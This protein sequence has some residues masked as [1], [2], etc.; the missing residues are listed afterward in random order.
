MGPRTQTCLIEC[1]NY[2]LN[3][4]CEDYE[5]VQPSGIW[6]I[7]EICDP[8][9]RIYKSTILLEDFRYETPPPPN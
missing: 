9:T 1:L 7:L 2:D 3:D 6:A 5:L 8:Q 4:L